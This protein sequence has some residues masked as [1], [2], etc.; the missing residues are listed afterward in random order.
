MNQ[1]SAQVL[2]KFKDYTTEKYKRFLGFPINLAIDF[3]AIKDFS[4]IPLNNIGDPFS[5]RTSF[6]LESESIK[7]LGDF[8]QIEPS[9]LWGYVTSGGSESNI[10]AIY[11]AKQNLENPV[12]VIAGV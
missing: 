11:I 9:D 10:Y 6:L 8:F 12:I 3:S 5:G 1:R 2:T 4:N 7:F